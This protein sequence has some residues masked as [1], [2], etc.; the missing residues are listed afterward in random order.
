MPC[1]FAALAAFTLALSLPAV[2]LADI[3]PP[4]GGTR[5]DPNCTADLQSIAGTTCTE[6][7]ISGSDT[8]CQVELGKDYSFV[9][10]YSAK[11]QIWCNGPE[12]TRVESPACALEGA[13]AT[14]G[15]ARGVALAALL[16]AA[17]WVMRRRRR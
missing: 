7:V 5:V 10:Q 16:G 3:P 12:R 9:C 8:S 4:D 11:V 2:A 13:P 14:G 1:R 15:P 17:A 6:C